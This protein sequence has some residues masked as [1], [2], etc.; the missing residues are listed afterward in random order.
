MARRDLGFSVD[1]DQRR[2]KRALKLLETEGGKTVA[3]IVNTK[4][5]FVL[6]DAQKNTDSVGEN[7]IRQVYGP[8]IKARRRQ[9]RAVFETHVE[10][11]TRA[12]RGNIVA[13]YLSDPK[14]RKAA[15]GM[16]RDEFFKTIR[17][18]RNAASR[19]RGYV[20]SGYNDSIRAFAR[21]TGFSANVSKG[22][23][24]RMKRSQA[25]P[26]QKE[27]SIAK[28]KTALARYRVATYWGPGKGQTPRSVQKAVKD[29]LRREAI[30][31]INHVEAK[32]L[33]NLRRKTWE[34]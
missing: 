10:R 32:Y 5:V 21:A 19:A 25:W 28:R 13:I 12:A 20:K 11:S 31:T 23:R 3:E 16:T 4:G 14:R 6:R 26:A 2:L 27:G 9:K 7:R 17:K 1:V 34:R 29:A 24:N 30:S 15:D 18:F 33:T 8:K 22:P